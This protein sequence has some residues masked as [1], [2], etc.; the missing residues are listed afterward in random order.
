M[1]GNSQI[2]ILL[3][4]G[5]SL[6]AGFPYTQSLTDKVVS[7][8]RVRRHTDG[9]CYSHQNQP[10]DEITI[11]ANCVIRRIYSEAE[12]YYAVHA[13]RRPNYEDVFYVLS[14]VQA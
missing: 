11:A 14:Q 5:S 12:R 3:G 10:V 13:E 6:P 4:A 8:D 1:N 2:A 9:I 7:G